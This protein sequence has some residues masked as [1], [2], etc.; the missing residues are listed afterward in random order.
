[1]EEEG[2]E[3][4]EGNDWYGPS[5]TRYRPYQGLVGTHL[6]IGGN[7]SPVL[8]ENTATIG[9]APARVLGNEFGLEVEVPADAQTG[10]LCVTV[11]ERTACGSVFTVLTRPQI[12]STSPSTVQVGSADVALIVYGDAFTPDSE[13]QLDGIPL[14]TRFQSTS[15]L[16]ATVPA[17]FFETTKRGEVAVFTRTAPGQGWS[18]AAILSV[19]NPG[20]GI[21]QIEPA[22]VPSGSCAPLFVMGRGFVPESV[23]MV[24]DVDIGTPFESATNMAMRFSASAFGAGE[25]LVQVRNPAPGGGVSAPFVLV[26]E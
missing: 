19:E 9:G 2:Y 13:I 23:L 24:D 21:D 17:S 6:E 15:Q 20:P 4:P 7:F 8:S 16:H 25:H 10:P 3:I 1:M 18:E 14:A 22:A 11:A 26:I 12:W 5:I